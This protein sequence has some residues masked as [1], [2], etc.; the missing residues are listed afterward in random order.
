MSET[1]KFTFAEL[2]NKRIY[3]HETWV[4]GE[5]YD[6]LR[7][8]HDGH[9]DYARI[10][11]EEL[12][13]LS[14]RVTTQDRLLAEILREIGANPWRPGTSPGF[15]HIDYCRWCH[16]SQSHGHSANCIIPRLEAA[17]STPADGATAEGKP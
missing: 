6:N 2:A 11:D 1:N 5:D 7:I 12:Q 10:R 16:Y 4:R 9:A 17:T 14:Q 3:G 8:A 15:E 13:V